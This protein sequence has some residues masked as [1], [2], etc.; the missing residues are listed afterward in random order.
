MKKEVWPFRR[1]NA[2]KVLLPGLLLGTL[3]T[4]C[5]FCQNVVK[6]SQFLDQLFHRDSEQLAS[7]AQSTQKNGTNWKSR[8][9]GA[10]EFMENHHHQ[11]LWQW[12][13]FPWADY[14]TEA[15]LPDTGRAGSLPR[16]PAMGWQHPPWACSSPALPSPPEAGCV[17]QTDSTSS[18][19][20]Y[21]S[22]SASTFRRWHA[23][24]VTGELNTQKGMKQKAKCEVC[25]SVLNIC[26]N[27]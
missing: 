18:L 4:I 14:S 22:R 1:Q 27:C 13:G 24:A 16:C 15:L 20:D 26:A 2:L 23:G 11:P 17:T 21:S 9:P 8:W 6:Q 5:A 7:I 10:E 25:E 3:N 19:G 12:E